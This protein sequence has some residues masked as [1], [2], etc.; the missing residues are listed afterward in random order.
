M[1]NEKEKH[2]KPWKTNLFSPDYQEGLINKD[3]IL[4]IISL[5]YKQITRDSVHQWRT[6]DD[7]W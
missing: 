5:K 1:L 2:K 6:Y 3:C 7:S 4:N